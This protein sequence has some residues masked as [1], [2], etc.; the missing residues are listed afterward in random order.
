LKPKDLIWEDFP[1]SIYV[2]RPSQK[3]VAGGWKDE[4]MNV[5]ATS[6]TVD[7][8]L[9]SA[10]SSG[11]RYYLGTYST[12][13]PTVMTTEEVTK[14]PFKVSAM[15]GQIIVLVHNAATMQVLGCV[16]KKTGTKKTRKGDAKSQFQQQ[17]ETGELLVNKFKLVRVSYD[18]SIEQALFLAGRSEGATESVPIM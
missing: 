17:Y 16:L 1:V 3:L 11:S 18:K 7:I 13:S 2:V 10:G 5:F 8:I 12:S 14:L 15:L 9:D 4:S 6:N